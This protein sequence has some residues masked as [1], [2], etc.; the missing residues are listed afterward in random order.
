MSIEYTIYCD[1]CSA[2]V[3]ASVVSASAARNVVRD[4]GGRTSLP[5]G[6]DLCPACVAA[7]KVAE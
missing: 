5:G 7:G 4:M 3:D 1:G 2:I 6:K